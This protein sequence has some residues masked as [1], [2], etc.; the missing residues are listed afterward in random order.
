M[1]K[2]IPTTG[3]PA[4]VAKSTTLHT[5]GTTSVVAVP[6]SPRNK[7]DAPK[8]TID[9]LT[10]QQKVD[11]GYCVKMP[12]SMNVTPDPGLPIFTADA[13]YGV[14]G[15]PISGDDAGYGVTG[16]TTAHQLQN[17]YL[18]TSGEA[19]WQIPGTGLPISPVPY[20]GDAIGNPNL[21]EWQKRLLDPTVP[22]VHIPPSSHSFTVNPS[23]SVLRWDTGN[24]DTGRDL[25]RVVETRHSPYAN[26]ETMATC[27]TPELAELVAK[28][29]NRFDASPVK[30][31]SI[32][33]AIL[34]KSDDTELITHNHFTSELKDLAGKVLTVL[35]AAITHPEQ[36]KAIK[37]LVKRE[38][39]SS[40]SKLWDYCFRAQDGCS[41]ESEGPQ[42]S[43]L[44]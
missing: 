4:S 43:V 8:C 17:C 40:I 25:Y 9:E 27:S 14:T 44:D 34:N 37:S 42:L 30:G 23:W 21:G 19:F 41:S 5:K 38:F 20:V 11:A 13:G 1:S 2:N 6:A 24:P 36:S 16:T 18:P 15:L 35:D 22:S 32:K 12:S 10:L 31:E 3:A 29:L 26:G 33:A 28:A 7:P 39:R